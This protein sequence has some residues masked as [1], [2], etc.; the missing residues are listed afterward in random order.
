PATSVATRR[1]E[2]GTNDVVAYDLFLRGQSLLRVRAVKQA[3]DLFSQAIA[4]DSKFARAYAGLSEALA[5]YPQ[6]TGTAATAV[7]DTAT[8]AADRGLALD[9]TLARAHLSLGLLYMNAFQ[10]EQSGVHFRRAVELDPSDAAAHLQ[11]G[12]YLVHTG[13]LRE[14]RIEIDRAKQLDPFSGVNAAWSG[15]ALYQAGKIDDAVAEC[16]AAFQLDSTNMI[17]LTISAFVNLGAKNNAVAVEYADR[18]A[19]APAFNGYT[20]YVQAVAGSKEKAQAIIHRLEA[21]KPPPAF[22]EMAIAMGYLGL[23]DTSRALDALTHS[24]DMRDPWT[25]VVPLCDPMYD[26]IRGSARFAQLLMRVG[27][28]LAVFVPPAGA[29]CGGAS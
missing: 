6:F 18:Q 27:L 28:E 26:P 14:A 4:R 23:R 3:R 11:L 13:R 29:R 10:W 22:G 1:K 24:T 17:V 5:F 7:F 15:Y 21:R 25:S 9:S 20:A 8:A 12:R 2:R 19:D 16:A